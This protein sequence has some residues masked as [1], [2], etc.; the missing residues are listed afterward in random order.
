M[1]LRDGDWQHDVQRICRALE[2]AGFKPQSPALNTARQN[3]S[4]KVISSYT[5]TGLTILSYNK[6]D[7]AETFLGLA[8]LN[9]VA[10]VLAAFAYGDYRQGLANQKWPSIGAMVLAGFCML[11]YIGFSTDST[12]QNKVTTA[13]VAPV[14][15]C[16]PPDHLPLRL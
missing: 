13:G 9:L 16:L 12:A 15:P 8:F 7:D 3:K 6:M 1:R 11:A 4:G 2:S 5:L 14:T 10:F